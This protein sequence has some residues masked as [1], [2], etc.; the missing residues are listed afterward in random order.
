MSINYPD[1]IGWE[2]D[3]NRWVELA[4]E[5]GAEGLDAKLTEVRTMLD[6]AL[7]DIKGLPLDA[8]LAAAEPN[9][10]ES[11]RSLRPTGRRRIWNDLPVEEYRNRLLGAF[12]GRCAGCTLGSPV[13]L[14]AIDKMSQWADYIGDEFPP[15]DYWSQ[16][17]R[18]HDLKYH[19]SPRAAF[20][21]SQMDG[22]PTDDDIIFTQLGLL[23]L[24]DHGPNFTIADVGEAW[25]RYV[26]YA[27]T[28]E[29]VALDNLR[30]GIP[31]EEAAARDNP[32]SQY[33][34]ADIRSDPWGYAAP[35]LP[36]MAAEMAY[37]DAYLSHRRNG[38]YSAMY[39]S[40]V[41]A[42]AFTVEDPVDALR[43][44]LEEIPKD[45]LFSQGIRWSLDIADEI[46][47][48]RDANAAINEAYGGM[49]RVHSINNGCLTVWGLTIGGRDF[50]KVIGETVAMSYDND[51]TAATAGSIA[52][53][54]LAKD[55]VPE[56][57]WKN[58]NN[59]ALTY[60]IGQGTFEIDDLVDR[61]TVQAQQVFGVA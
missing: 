22:V 26:P 36:E 32:Y 29:E 39:F 44:G 18:P 57:W 35:G 23:I 34:G 28:A 49:P 41:I 30:A 33:I 21:P 12:L 58:F 5:L 48:Y 45:C 8:K 59:K 17:E 14:F 50:T 52:G 53:A 13:E 11:I 43:I 61:F 2:N 42:A 1:A 16:V 51:C 3:F 7:G 47:D 55:G 54:V 60:L 20:T 25:L 27:H 10:L 56:H 46:K 40:A 19:V 37:R 6:R 4:A 31:A 9:D 15:T 38:I 24:E